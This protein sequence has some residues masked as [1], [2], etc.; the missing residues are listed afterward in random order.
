MQAFYK[1]SFT[2]WLVFGA[3]FAAVFLY[4][5]L[6]R[7]AR[8]LKSQNLERVCG[9]PVASL[10]ASN[11]SYGLRI[12][13]TEVFRVSI[14]QGLVLLNL[15]A[16]KDFKLITNYVREIHEGK[17]TGVSYKDL[18]PAVYISIKSATSSVPWR[19]SA[20]AHEAYHIKLYR[21]AHN[22]YNDYKARVIAEETVIKYQRSV[23]DQVGGSRYELE[24]IDTVKG[25]HFDTNGDGKYTIEDWL[26]RDW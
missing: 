15:S 20:I 19:A 18:N 10:I 8:V 9:L 22:S 1:K 24:Y 23:L 5:H 4:N 17:R 6:S 2:I 3:C 21:D 12:T 7:R 11:E 13:G 26:Q 25:D 14:M 16:P